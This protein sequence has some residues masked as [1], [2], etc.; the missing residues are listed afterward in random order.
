MVISQLLIGVMYL[1]T[2]RAA[3][4]AVFGQAVVSL[5]VA[6][7][8]VVLFDMGLSSYLVREVAS[9]RL[10]VAEAFGIV[11]AKQVAAPVLVGV[12]F[13]AS[14][15]T[16]LDSLSAFLVGL[17]ALFTWEAQSSNA[18]LRAQKRFGLCSRNQVLAR[19]IAVL[20]LVVAGRFLNPILAL[21]AGLVLAWALEGCANLITGGTPR[22]KP[23]DLGRSASAQRAAFTYG[24][25]SLSGSAQQLDTPAVSV[26]GGIYAA[27]LYGAAGR[28]QGPLT[29][30]SQSMAAVAAPWLARAS[31]Q[32]AQL[33]RE[34]R[35]IQKLAAILAVAPLIAAAVGPFLIPLLLT[36]SYKS[37]VTTFIILCF[38]ASLLSLNQ[39][40]IVILQ[41]RHDTGFVAAALASSIAAGLLATYLLARSGDASLAAL[42]YVLTQGSLLGSTQF[43]LRKLRRCELVACEEG[44]GNA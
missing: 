43:R 10:T 14:S 42:G 31:D 2:A 16:G 7:I 40:A 36:D 12:A 18:L 3:S 1:L 19:V 27:G 11:R 26:G 25:S 4:P 30:M 8:L 20:W 13:V 44:T 22:S 29:F 15:V 37:S 38:G 39:S 17:V 23:T 35:R 5:S 33:L 34:E 21:A 28:L 24:L 41:N 9:A 6:T 32:R